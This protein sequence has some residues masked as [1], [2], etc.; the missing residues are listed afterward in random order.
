MNKPVAFRINEVYRQEVVRLHSARKKSRVI[1]ASGDIDASGDEIEQTFRDLLRRR[2]PNQYFVGHGHIVDKTLK[3]SPQ[4]DVII[5]D[6]N[7]TPVLFEA[8]NGCQYFPWESVYAVGEIKSTY[9]KGKHFVSAFAASIKKLKTELERERTP[10]NY[11]RNGIILGEAFTT[12]ESRP[13]T[14]PLFAFIVFFD[15]GDVTRIDLC[16]E[17]CTNND[18]NLPA[19]AAFLDGSVVVKAELLPF[20]GKSKMGAI[21]LDPLNIVSRSDVHWMHVK[22][23][24]ASDKGAQ[25]LV[26]LMLGLF[27]HLNRCV[28]MTPRIDDYLNT[29]LKSAANHPEPLSLSGIVQAAKFAGLDFPPQAEEFFQFRIAEGTSPLARVTQKEIDRYLKKAGLSEETFFEPNA[30][31]NSRREPSNRTRAKK[32]NVTAAGE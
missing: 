11:L 26:V 2:L 8:E 19:I 17:Y 18:D 12:D 16:R 29:V 32:G 3:V 4:F 21:Q 9:A 28:L 27:N 20:D 25:A 30:E 7:A 5:A 23:R 22:Y 10:P 24:D 14:N 13:Y 15:S 1:H 31:Q 6:N